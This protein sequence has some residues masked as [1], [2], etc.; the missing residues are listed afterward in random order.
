[1]LVQRPN[2]LQ[3]MYC[4]TYCRCI[5]WVRRI[6]QECPDILHTK[7]FHQQHD[8]IERDSLNLRGIVLRQVL[9]RHLAREEV[10]GYAGANTASAAAALH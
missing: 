5:R 1:M 4:R 10:D 3:T 2:L 7:G 6:R 8:V 9:L